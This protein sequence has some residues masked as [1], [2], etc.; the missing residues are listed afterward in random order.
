M[1]S[2]CVF[3]DVFGSTECNCHDLIRRSME[4]IAAE[5]AGVLVYL[6]QTGRGLLLKQNPGDLAE[7][8][9]HNREYRNYLRPD[10][11]RLLAV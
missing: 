2:H 9:P 4:M 10:G 7:L 1:H 3:G 11:Q 8:K 6:H 5:G